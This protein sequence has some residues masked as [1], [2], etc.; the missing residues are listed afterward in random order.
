MRGM[1]GEEMKERRKRLRAEGGKKVNQTLLA[2][3]LD[4][5]IMTVSRYESN[6]RPIPRVVELAL[7][8]VEARL[9]PTAKKKA[10]K[11]SV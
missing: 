2:E 1:T 7:E 3:L 8:A 9:K 11:S 4:V 6:K 10:K 5:D